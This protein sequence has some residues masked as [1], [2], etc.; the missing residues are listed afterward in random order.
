ML[1]ITVHAR[2]EDVKLELEGRL[3]AE[4]I[5]VLGHECLRWSELGK[6]VLL[7]L[8]EVTFVDGGGVE[9]L[10]SFDPD[11][12]EVVAASSLVMDWLKDAE[13]L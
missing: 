10:R 6:R 4:G 13:D 1:R 2:P 5:D 12:V 11:R 3:D 7:D 8:S 9:L